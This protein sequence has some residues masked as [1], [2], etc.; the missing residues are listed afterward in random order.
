MSGRCVRGGSKR[1]RDHHDAYHNAP[2]HTPKTPA[3]SEGFHQPRTV[4]KRL[5]KLLTT[6]HNGPDCILQVA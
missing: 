5:P 1:Q 3:D 6:H 4:T 2:P